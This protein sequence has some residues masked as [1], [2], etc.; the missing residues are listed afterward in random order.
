MRSCH[1]YA[2]SPDGQPA[3]PAARSE[4]LLTP[5][6]V[7]CHRASGWPVCRVLAAGSL[8]LPPKRGCAVSSPQFGAHVRRCCATSQ[9]PL[10]RSGLQWGPAR[11]PQRLPPALPSLYRRLQKTSSASRAAVASTGP[12]LRGGSR[13]RPCGPAVSDTAWPAPDEFTQAS[14]GSE[15]S[16]APVLTR[17]LWVS[18][19]G[20]LRLSWCGRAI[21]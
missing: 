2:S 14:R 1:G 17:A 12:R 5:L 8:D 7:Y 9:A 13:G 19:A 3:T 21:G 6:T 4:T 18:H 16:R 11:A 15:C 10:S 20:W